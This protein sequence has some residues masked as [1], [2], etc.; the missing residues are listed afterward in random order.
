MPSPIAQWHAGCISS[1]VDTGPRESR[2]SQSHKD[3][4]EYIDQRFRLLI[5]GLTDFA[6]FMSD[7]SGAASS[8]NPGVDQGLGYTGEFIGL[9]SRRSSPLKTLPWSAPP[10]SSGALATGRSDDKRD[11][12]RG[13]EPVPR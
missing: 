4:P 13:Q 7:L 3:E 12:L 1:A 10:R 5:E 11:H 2:L 9:P 6:V 8:W